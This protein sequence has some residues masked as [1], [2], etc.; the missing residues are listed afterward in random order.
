MSGP[1]PSREEILAAIDA[2]LIHDRPEDAL[3]A[4]DAFLTREPHD[5]E[6]FHAR[7]LCLRELDR[8]EESLEAQERAIE[9]DPGLAEA[10][11]EAAE[12]WL[13]DLGDEVKALEVAR[14]GGRRLEEPSHRAEL[15]LLK[16]AALS[17]LEDYHGALR[18]LEEAEKLQ[19][20]HADLRIERAQVLVELSRM[21]DAE[22]ALRACLDRE[23]IGARAHQLLAF[24]LDYTGRRAEATGHFQAAA[25]ADPELAPLPPRLGEDEFEAVVDAAL[26]AIPE[27]FAGNLSNVEISV[28]DYPDRE[29]CRRH[30][31]GPMTLGLFIGRSPTDPREGEL[32]DRIVLFQRCLENVVGHPDELVEEIGVTVRHEV[33]HALGLDEHDLIDAGHG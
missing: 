15:L 28:E 1:A 32:P 18:V 14:R 29:F 7:G 22:V 3:A 4:C 17:G 8:P 20:D 11:L 27:R 6:V 5:A 23:D 21:E 26:K 19:P 10:Y 12:L 31:C 33:G 24:V 25:E 13:E 2:D 9:L 30:D 16:A